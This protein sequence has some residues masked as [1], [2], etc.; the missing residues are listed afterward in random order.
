MPTES[1]NRKDECYQIIN[2]DCLGNIYSYIHYIITPHCL[3]KQRKVLTLYTRPAMHRQETN[4]VV[5][6]KSHPIK[7][8]TLND[9]EFKVWKMK[10]KHRILLWKRLLNAKYLIWLL[11]TIPLCREWMNKSIVKYMYV[12]MQSESMSKLRLTSSPCT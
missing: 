4:L 10:V 6:Q 2:G 3:F 12:H 9:S 5:T 7:Q 1:L 11:F 8:K